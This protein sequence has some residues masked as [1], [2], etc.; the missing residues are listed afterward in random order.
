MPGDEGS[1]FG[2]TLG[3]PALRFSVGC[4]GADG[5]DGTVN[6]FLLEQAVPV[7]AGLGCT[8]ETDEGLFG[9]GIEQAST[10]KHFEVVE[11]FVS[12]NGAF[13]RDGDG[14]GKQES[15]PI[16]VVT[17]ADGDAGEEGDE[18]GFKGILEQDGTI[19]LACAQLP[20][21][22]PLASPIARAAGRGVGDDFVA[23][24]LAAVEIGNPRQG[25]DSDVGA[26][27]TGT[28]GAQRR[29]THDGVAHPIGGAHDQLL[30][31]WNRVGQ[32]TIMP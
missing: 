18:R 25:E 3:D 1:R 13:L 32:G 12:R 29:Q 2:E 30:H 5:D 10:A 15:A 23:E 26:G 8:I 24:G 7:M 28:N 20:G 4:S 21:E 31:R 17:D 14:V 27:E 11:A 9:E 16:A 22:T 19:E 6:T